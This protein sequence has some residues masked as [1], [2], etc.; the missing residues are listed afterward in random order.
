MYEQNIS[1]NNPNVVFSGE[2]SA[3][4][5]METKTTLSIN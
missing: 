1:A 4:T 5:P 2:Y 3:I